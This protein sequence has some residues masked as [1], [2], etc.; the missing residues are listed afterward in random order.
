MNHE[1]L[2]TGSPLWWKMLLFS[3]AAIVLLIY[4]GL[5]DQ[6]TSKIIAA[7]TGWMLI[8][9]AILVHPYLAITGKWTLQTSLPLNLCSLSGILS[10]IVLLK[11]N[12]LAYEFLLYWGIPGGL[13]ALLTPEFTQGSNGILLYEYTITHAGILFSPLYLSIV[14]Q[15]RPR[16]NSWLLIFLYSQL[17]IPIVGYIDYLVDANYMYLLKKPAA[18]NP[19]VIGTWPWYLVIFELFLLIH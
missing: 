1:T 11:R 18:H 5:R 14:F 12:Q 2:D 9:I 19:L 8:A 17:L 4:S 13:H 3:A 7:I 10:G 16:M 15:M 6:R